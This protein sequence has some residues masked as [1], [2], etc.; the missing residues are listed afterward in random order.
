MGSFF[1]AIYI[2]TQDLDILLCSNYTRKE[3]NNDSKKK[4]Q[5]TT[6]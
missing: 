2:L 5:I 6:T 4:K 3:V 1:E